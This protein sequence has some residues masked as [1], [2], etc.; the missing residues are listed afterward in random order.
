MELPPNILLFPDRRV[1]AAQ[2]ARLASRGDGDCNRDQSCDLDARGRC[3]FGGRP[4]SVPFASSTP[5]LRRCRAKIE[6]NYI[7][8]G[9]QDYHFAL[10]VLGAP[11]DLGT[12]IREYQHV[13]KVGVNY[14]FDTFGKGK[15]PVMAKY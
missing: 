13:M 2:R 1:R 11:I 3:F 10:A 14:R 9:S 5:S 12:K 6:Y 8:Y 7:D 4:P 15:A